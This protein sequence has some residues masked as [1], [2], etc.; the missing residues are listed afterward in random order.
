MAGYREREGGGR[1]GDGRKLFKRDHWDTRCDAPTF[2]TYFSSSSVSVTLSL[3]S[4]LSLSIALQST[5]RERECGVHVV[6]C[7]KF[8][9]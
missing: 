4:P 5:K 3:F 8:Y 1:V 7:N 2:A 6:R 9:S